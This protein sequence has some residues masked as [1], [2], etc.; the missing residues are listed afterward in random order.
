[1]KST[2]S[3]KTNDNA[4]ERKLAV[5]PDGRFNYYTCESDCMFN[6]TFYARGKVYQIP[7]GTEVDQPRLVPMYEGDSSSPDNKASSI[8]D[9]CSEHLS[10]I[11][12]DKVF[13]GIV[14]RR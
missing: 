3:S 1:M 8:Y 12:M 9:P 4:E 7:I 2:V 5:S 14:G 13:A 10:G 6:N 11:K